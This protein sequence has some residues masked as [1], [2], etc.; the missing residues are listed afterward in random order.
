MLEVWAEIRTRASPWVLGHFSVAVPTSAERVCLL[1]LRRFR[2][3]PGGP[4]ASDSTF[5]E[6]RAGSLECSGPVRGGGGERLE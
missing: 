5:A 3:L 4:T 2:P 6:F 1:S